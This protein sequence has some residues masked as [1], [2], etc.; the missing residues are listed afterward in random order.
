[1]R[2]LV[3]GLTVFFFNNLAAQN[4]DPALYDVRALLTKMSYNNNERFKKTFLLVDQAYKPVSIEKIKEIDSVW[5]LFCDD[6]IEFIEW[7]I[8][9]YKPVTFDS[10][11]A[12]NW[13]RVPI[14]DYETVFRIRSVKDDTDAWEEY[15]KKFGP[16]YFLLSYPLF[17]KSGNICVFYAESSLGWLG[18]D[19]GYSIYIKEKGVWKFF[20]TRGQWSS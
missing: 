9:N 11:Y 14:D 20:Q 1:M 6:D 8:K 15:H 17:N 4:V 16:G 19:G 18:G 7:Q 13:T 5:D 3:F 2:Y 10:S 12:I